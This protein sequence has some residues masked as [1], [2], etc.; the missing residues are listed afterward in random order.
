M[1]DEASGPYSPRSLAVKLRQD[2]IE[3]WTRHAVLRAA[4]WGHLEQRKSRTTLPRI[5]GL[6][7]A[8]ASTPA[9][10]AHGDLR[11]AVVAALLAY[12]R[13]QKG[14]VAGSALEFTPDANANEL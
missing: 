6:G 14:Y 9:P 1:A 5:G 4:A 10:S 2:D 12:G 13:S 3:G 8:P 7:P 11:K